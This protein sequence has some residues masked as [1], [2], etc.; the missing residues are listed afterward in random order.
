MTSSRVIAMK[1]PTKRK[2][3]AVNWD[4]MFLTAAKEETLKAATPCLK[5]HQLIWE[6]D[7]PTTN[8]EMQWACN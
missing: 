4:T 7:M 2:G 6:V 3:H 1:T 5:S 8:A